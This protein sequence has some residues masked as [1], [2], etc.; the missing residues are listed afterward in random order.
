MGKGVKTPTQE[1]AG[2]R[3]PFQG[4][5]AVILKRAIKEAEKSP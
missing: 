3:T 2:V 4:S 5:K 1:D